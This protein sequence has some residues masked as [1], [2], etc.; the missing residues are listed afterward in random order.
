MCA[1]PFASCVAS[2]CI[3]A[4][5]ALGRPLFPSEDAPDQL[6][7]IVRV[8]GALAPTHAARLAT[9]LCPAQCARINEFADVEEPAINR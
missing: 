6:R 1:L 4:E 2:G 9:L 3:I 8:C 7:H 5:L